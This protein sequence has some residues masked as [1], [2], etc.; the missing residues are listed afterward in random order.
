MNPF[1]NPN[2]RDVLLPSGCKDLMDVLRRSRPVH[3]PEIHVGEL[4]HLHDYITKLMATLAPAA[5][6][7][8]ASMDGLMRIG[9]ERSA[10]SI[11]VFPELGVSEQGRGVEEFFAE[12]GIQ[13]CVDYLAWSA[14]SPNRI[15]GFTLPFDSSEASRLVAELIHSVYGPY[16]EA[17]LEFGYF[18][19]EAA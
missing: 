4:D 13:A 16:A 7:T 10:E 17:E 11:A 15:L 19:T 8:I 12:R 18:E 14:G 9:L 2:K 5:V 6:L 3:Q 1:V